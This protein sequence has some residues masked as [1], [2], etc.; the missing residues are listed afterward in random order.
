MIV[1]PMSLISFENCKMNS[2]DRTPNVYTDTHWAL[3]FESFENG[4]RIL[5]HTAPA[6]VHQ[7]LCPLFAGLS[8]GRKVFQFKSYYC[9]ERGPADG[10]ASAIAARGGDDSASI[11]QR[12][13]LR[14]CRGISPDPICRL[15]AESFYSTDKGVNN[16]EK[17]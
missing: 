17:I 3:F 8:K 15:R 13:L 7:P 11:A 6:V 9:L 12:Y 16:G 10:G 5:I 2:N 14:A 1:M 4:M